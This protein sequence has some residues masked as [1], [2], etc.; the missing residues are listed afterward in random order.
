MLMD[1]GADGHSLRGAVRSDSV[2]AV[3]YVIASR[4]TGL[5]SS[6]TARPTGL[7]SCA[8][9]STTPWYSDFEERKK[10]NRAAFQ[11]I[12]FQLKRRH[13]LFPY[14]T[15]FYAGCTCIAIDDPQAI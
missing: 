5:S 11:K 3:S 1:N 15:A 2:G 14:Y 12:P 4:A 8:Q 6:A 9:Q 7:S 10:A 13:S